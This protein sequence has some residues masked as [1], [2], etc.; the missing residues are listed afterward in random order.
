VGDGNGLS[1]GGRWAWRWKDW[2]DRRFVERF[3][4]LPE[5]SM[6]PTRGASAIEPPPSLALDLPDVQRC[7]GCAAK[8]G[9]EPLRRVPRR[10]PGGFHFRGG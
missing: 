3:S 2:I 5:P 1:F 10:P 4:D 8:V 9:A 6:T 7:G